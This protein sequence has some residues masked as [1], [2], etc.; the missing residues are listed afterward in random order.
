LTSKAIIGSHDGGDEK[1]D[2]MGI[3]GFTTLETA[4]TFGR[5]SLVR[6]NALDILTLA[7]RHIVITVDISSG[8]GGRSGLGLFCRLRRKHIIH[9]IISHK[10]KVV[11]N[12]LQSTDT[13]A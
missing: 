7:A 5:L 11:D 1:L 3:R 9:A 12:Q 6:Q 8:S 13:K 2:G 10:R 4:P